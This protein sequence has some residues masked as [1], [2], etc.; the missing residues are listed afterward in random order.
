MPMSATPQTGICLRDAIRMPLT[1]GRRGV[2]DLVTGGEQARGRNFHDFHTVFQGAF[3][4]KTRIGFLYFLKLAHAGKIERFGEGEGSGSVAPVAAQPA[5]ED[6]VET[7]HHL[8]G[9]RQNS[10][11]SEGVG[12][13]KGLVLKQNGF[14]ASHGQAIFFRPSLAF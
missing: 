5:A 8:D 6:D 9:A 13:L 4:P 14:I 3:A 1:D 11:R 10:R 2:L 7:I 12:T